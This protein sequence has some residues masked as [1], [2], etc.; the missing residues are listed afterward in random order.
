M[1]RIV[2][3]VLMIVLACAVVHAVVKASRA[4]RIDWTG[5]TAFIC[6]IVMAFYLRH[7][8]GWG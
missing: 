3:M 5:V 8:T 6:F 4:G 7:L 1:I 2:L